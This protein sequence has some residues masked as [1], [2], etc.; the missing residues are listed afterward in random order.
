MASVQWQNVSDFVRTAE[1]GS[2][3][4][5]RFK[6]VIQKKEYFKHKHLL[7]IHGRFPNGN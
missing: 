5:E 7:E 3:L 4:S 6:L 1:I 2:L